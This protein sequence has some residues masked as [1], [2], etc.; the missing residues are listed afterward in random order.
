MPKREVA[1]SACA[2]PE[3][4]VRNDIPGKGH[5]RAL[6][7]LRIAGHGTGDPP[8][9]L[10]S[11]VFYDLAERYDSWFALALRRHAYDDLKIRF[12]GR[13]SS[14]ALQKV[15]EMCSRF[16]AGG[17]TQSLDHNLAAFRCGR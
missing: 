13:A 6:A 11:L 15:G 5:P 10:T 4:P 17:Q 12:V 7:E 3:A 9:K 14:L 16:L 2:P 1:D 8:R